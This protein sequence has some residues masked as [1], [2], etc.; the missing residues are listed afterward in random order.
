M[1]AERAPDDATRD[2]LHEFFEPSARAI[3]GLEK[4]LAAVGL[5]EEA[6]SLDLRRP[7]DCFGQVWSTVFRAQ[8]LD[9]AEAGE[10]E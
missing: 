2:Y 1:L 10:A 6:L 5:L 3:V 4:A 8:E 7:W 9:R